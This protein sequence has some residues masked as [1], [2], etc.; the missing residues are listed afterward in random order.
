MGVHQKPRSAHWVVGAVYPDV[1][2]SAEALQTIRSQ[3]KDDSP[4]WELQD[5]A[6]VPDHSQPNL[7]RQADNSQC[8]R[9]LSGDQSGRGATGR[10]RDSGLDE[11]A[12]HASRTGSKRR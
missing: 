1:G 6:V 7:G 2:T 3:A 9:H 10:L 5:E 4:T 8:G 12:G 11:P